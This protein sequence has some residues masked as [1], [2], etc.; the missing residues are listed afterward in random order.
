MSTAIGSIAQ[1]SCPDGRLTG[2]DGHRSLHRS[3]R[4][5]RRAGPPG[6]AVQRPI[7]LL[8][9]R[10]QGRPRQCSRA[11]ARCCCPTPP[12]GSR[13]ARSTPA[14][15][16]DKIGHRPDPGDAAADRAAARLR[17]RR[18]QGFFAVRTPQR[19]PLHARRPVHVQ[20]ARAGSSTPRATRCSPRTG[21]R[22]PS[23]PKGTVAASALGVFNVPNAAKQG[24][25]LSPA[26]LPAAAAASCARASSSSRASTRS[27]RWS[28]MISSLRSYE[29][30]QNAIQAISE[31]MQQSAQHRSARSE[32]VDASRSVRRGLR[33]GGAAAAVRRGLQRPRQPRHARL[34]GRDRRLPRPALHQRRQLTARTSPPA[35]GCGVRDRRPRAAEQGAI[36][37]T[38]RPLDVAIQGDGY[39][40]VR[41]PDGT[42]GLTRNGALRDQ[43]QG[44]ADHRAGHAGAAPDHDPA[45]NRPLQRDDRRATATSSS[46]ARSSARSRSS[47][48]PR[49]TAWSPTATACSAPPP[50]AARSARAN[51]RHAP[52]GRP[53]G[54]ERRHGTSDGHR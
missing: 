46:A 21:R 13:S 30:G 27:T 47:T 40:E 20:R 43:R 14:S 10:L 18:A 38:G 24:E 6:P 7:E 5:A 32:V 15:K 2:I 44:P 35:P 42:I 33:D 45:G 17:D 26:P 41:R 34:P 3:L 37:Q 1:G 9:A 23:A 54:L 51:G 29:T 53:R 16:I 25:N 31:T 48:C 22:S 12:P 39:I 19:G 36:Q 50:P 8:D 49:P 52:A 11:S 4:N 28:D